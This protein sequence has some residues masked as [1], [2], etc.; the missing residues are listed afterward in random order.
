MI[1]AWRVVGICGLLTALLAVSGCVSTPNQGNTTVSATETTAPRQTT[2]AQP[3]GLDDRLYELTRADN[4]TRYAESHGLRLQNGS[5]QAVVILTANSTLPQ[6]YGIT[7][8]IRSDDRVQGWVPVDSLVDVTQDRN[9]S[10]VEPP[11][12]PGSA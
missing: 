5:V 1:A 10:R 9:V 2:P 8:D 6:G 11:L 3:A 4:R 12:R 7:V